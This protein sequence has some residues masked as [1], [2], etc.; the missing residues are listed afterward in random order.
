MIE[1]TTKGW[2]Y[3]SYAWRPD[4]SATLVPSAGILTASRFADGVRHAIPSR[5]DC[6]ACH[7]AGPSRLLSLG[8]L[9][10]SPD[11]DPLAPH[12]EPLPDG[13]VTLQTLLDRGLL[14]NLPAPFA[15]RA[16]RIERRHRRVER[17]AL[18][19]LHSNCGMCHTGAG[20]MASLG[21]V[22]QYP[23][24]QSPSACAGTADH[25]SPNPVTSRPRPSPDMHDR[26]APGNPDA[27]MLR[28]P[29]GLASSRAPD[30]PA[31][32]SH[33][34]RGGR[35]PAATMDRRRHRAHP[36]R[37][38]RPL[39]DSTG[40]SHEDARQHVR[41]LSLACMAVA[42]SCCCSCGRPIR[43]PRARRHV[44]RRR[45]LARAH[46]EYLVKTGGCDDCHTPWKMGDN[47]PEP[48][49]TRRLLGTSGRPR[50]QRSRRD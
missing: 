12:A 28:G 22:L 29:H 32:Q 9:Q 2:R 39:A 50:G 19:Y 6:T 16:P 44:A 3:A 48:D 45:R 38:A 31:R 43:A 5:T 27:S 7:E 30:A 33:R 8:T 15:R 21:F 1:R 26:I 4:G 25:H 13:A 47:G 17:A 14:R 41:R 23:L 42:R 10:L 49:M 34:R 36:C 46:G 37:R 11:R 18:G 40:G 35:G 24:T 20:E